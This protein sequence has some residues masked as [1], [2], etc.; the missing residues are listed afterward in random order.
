M[1]DET[2]NKQLSQPQ[3]GPEMD[4]EQPISALTPE[5]EKRYMASQW[6][7]MWLKFRKHKVAVIGMIFLSFLYLGAIFCEFFAPYDPHARYTDLIFA[8]PQR[9]RFVDQDGNFGIRPFVYGWTGEYSRETFKYEYSP[10]YSQKYYI[11][12]FAKGDPYKLWGF[13]PSNIHFVGIRTDGTQD[14][15]LPATMFLLGSDRMGRDLLSR[16]IYGSR[17]SLSVG[18]IGIAISF[19]IG[20]V[21]GGLS[22]YFGGVTDNVIQRI[23]ETI[24]CI[25][26]LPLWMA[27]SAA[28]PA[29]WSPLKVYFG[30]TIVLSFRGWTGLG[31]VIR[32]QILSLR[33]QDFTTAAMIAGARPFAII[34]EHLLP[35]CFSYILVSLSLSIPGM[36]LGETSLSFLGL[37]I[38]PP[39]ISWGV[40]LQSAQ[41]MKTVAYNP[42][43]MTPVL[44]VIL[45]V[46]AFNFVGDGLRD[47]ADPYK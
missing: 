31:R 18:L 25:P 21:M 34:R 38:R 23:I 33:E 39:I 3:G 13:I 32:G 30:I 11:R 44:F 36:I 10:D 22:G 45:T 8:P 17:V 2:A 47:A 27:L 7:L 29:T 35:S 19:V 12:F 26:T 28:L 9:I 16:I 40:L 37:G 46:L 20:L 15:E 5:D 43:L 42:W 6:T 1:I 14:A 4:A 24:R 41:S